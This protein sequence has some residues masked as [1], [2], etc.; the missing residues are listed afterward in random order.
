MVRKRYLLTLLI[1]SRLDIRLEKCPIF[2]LHANS[3]ASFSQSV[4]RSLLGSDLMPVR[5]S[6]G[7]ACKLAVAS[8]GR[9]TIVFDLHKV[10]DVVADRCMVEDKVD[11]CSS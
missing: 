10:V 4:A 11:R 7:L 8:A 1:N 5:S 6:M 9:T 2:C 3:S